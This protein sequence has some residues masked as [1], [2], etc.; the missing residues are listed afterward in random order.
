MA[1]YKASK[2]QVP[3]RQG[4][5]AVFRHPVRK[6]KTGKIY[7]VRAG[8]GTRDESEADRLIG[9]LDELLQNESYWNLGARDIAGRLYDRRVV[10]IFYE[11]M[12]ASP[13]NSWDTREAVIPLPG[14]NAGYSKV[15]LVGQTGAGKT[16]LLRQLI[17][18]DPIRD[19]FPSTSAAKTTT[20]DIE[21]V[22]AQDPTY[23]AVVTFMPQ[24]L[25]RNYVKECVVSAVVTAAEGAQPEDVL[26]KLLEHVE[27]RFRLSYI[28]GGTPEIQ[29][30]DNTL[31]DRLE[32]ELSNDESRDELS[33][34]S[35][36]D[37]AVMNKKLADYVSRIEAAG[38][39]QKE[40]VFISLGLSSEQ[41][42]S[43]EE[44]DTIQDLLEENIQDTEDIEQ[45][46]D[47]I[48]DDIQSRFSYLGI[49][50]L[51]RNSVEWP[52]LWKLESDDRA[53]FIKAVNTFTSN[54]KPNFGRLL[55]PLVQGLRVQGPFKPAWFDASELP[56][57]VLMD[58]EGLGHTP[59]TVA[60]LPTSVTQSYEKADMILL[61]D[62]AIM[63]MQAATM[64]VLRSLCA[65]GHQSKL[66][67]AFTHVD[68]VKGDNL[69]TGE[70][71]RKYIV[72]SVR[73]ALNSLRENLGYSILR[74]LERTV[75]QR[76]FFL[77][78]VQDTVPATLRFTRRQLIEL[79]DALQK[80][81]R[82]GRISDYHPKYDL[83][84]LVIAVHS[85]TQK[86]Q[87]EWRARLLTEHWTR[88]KA[89]SRR[90]AVFQMDEYDTLRPVSDLIRLL[91][92]HLT[93][94]VTNPREWRVAPGEEIR[95]DVINHIL[96]SIYSQL[97]GLAFQRICQTFIREWLSAYELHGLGTTRM[98]AQQI[99]NIYELAVPI[100][101]E[102]PR[103]E[104]S[105][106]LDEVRNIFKT[107][108]EAVAAD[109]L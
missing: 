55:T 67:L 77:S 51:Q 74:S 32:D 56:K 22:I 92:E 91:S 36:S 81:T 64:T 100:P 28:L 41:A 14:L 23:K 58:G 7:R 98:R 15:R 49:G 62:N 75:D 70:D 85:A 27:Q 84:N 35:P 43:A 71:K 39:G 20:C 101:G 80:P 21:I 63:P 9:Q 25:A 31:D 99:Q 83:A 54:Y 48:M 4:W 79:V 16:T 42:L 34:L 24:D 46:V 89:L 44:R 93:P 86:F 18:S 12:T 90:V 87:D 50:V 2:T 29:E 65:G 45:I 96:Q 13:V 11:N 109:V 17:G 104:S 73:N 106:L 5:V 95:T 38:R 26:R 94:F 66:A 105:L 57:L 6:D 3:G 88:V 19:R 103:P 61:V 60:S 53:S 76:T 82:P 40:T 108:A 1:A 37:R 59:E 30:V 52:M 68:L 47:E 97:H 102:T 72:N 107:A 10:D 8:L 69:R 78:N 33:E